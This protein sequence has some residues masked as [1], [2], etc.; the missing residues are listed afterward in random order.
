VGGKKRGERREGKAVLDQTRT[1]NG[2]FRLGCGCKVVALAL[3]KGEV[4]DRSRN[5]PRGWAWGV[6]TK[7]DKGKKAAETDQ[8]EKKGERGHEGSSVAF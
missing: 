6:T 5:T 1:G 7:L 3:A 2:A 8:D 4:A